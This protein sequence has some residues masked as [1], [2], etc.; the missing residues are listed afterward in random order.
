M[1]KMHRMPAH[2]STHAKR[3]SPNAREARHAKSGHRRVLLGESCKGNGSMDKPTPKKSGEPTLHEYIGK[4]YRITM[5]EITD[6]G[7]THFTGEVTFSAGSANKGGA[8]YNGLGA[9]LLATES[10]FEGLEATR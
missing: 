7:L 9:S 4:T 5:P 2:N 8:V 3:K 1:P 10:T 6:Y